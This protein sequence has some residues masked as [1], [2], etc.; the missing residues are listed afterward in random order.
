MELEE[1]SRLLPSRLPS[2]AFYFWLWRLVFALG[3]RNSFD[4]E[5]E[6]DEFS[7]RL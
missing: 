6:L 2:R 1:F 3:V 7:L 4:N 5:V